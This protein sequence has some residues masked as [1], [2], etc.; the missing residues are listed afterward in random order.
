MS[1]P[2]KKYRPRWEAAHQ[3]YSI[4]KEA[5]VELQLQPHLALEAF[6]RG[7]AQET[8]HWHDLAARINLGV[9]MQHRLKLGICFGPA[10]DALHASL[11]RYGRT[12]A[13]GMTGAEF[14]TIADAL[15]TIDDLQQQM[16]RPE[17]WA[18]IRLVLET[19]GA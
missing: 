17:L 9:A 1:K 11:E 13:M 7:I 12:G 5:Q 14:H 6:R 15:N 18:C 3:L 19:A 2:R 4:P 8:P 16:T 10:L